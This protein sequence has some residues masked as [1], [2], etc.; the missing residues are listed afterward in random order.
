MTK[1]NIHGS[2]VTRD[3]FRFDNEQHFKVVNYI[4]RNSIISLSY[5]SVDLSS[6]NTVKDVRK[7][8]WEERMIYYDCNKSALKKIVSDDCDYLIID[9]IDE[10]FGIIESEKGN[11]TYSQV[12]QRSKQLNELS[13]YKVIDIKEDTDFFYNAYRDYAMFLREKFDVK[14]IIIHEVY[15][16][17]NYL[18]N[19]NKLHLFDENEIKKSKRVCSKIRKGYELLQ[20]FLPEA[21]VLKMPPNTIAYENHA[22]GKASVHFTDDYY[23]E[24]LTEIVGI[25]NTKVEEFSNA[26][27][28]SGI[29]PPYDSKYDSFKNVK[30]S[31]QL[32]T[33]NTVNAN[34]MENFNIDLQH[35][36]YQDI[37]GYHFEIFLY[38]KN[39]PKLYVVFG[40]ARTYKGVKR[41][42]P[43]FNRW[44]YCSFLDG[45]LL[46]IEDPMYY[47]YDDLLL[48]WFYGTDSDNGCR[49]G[50]TRLIQNIMNTLGIT[51]DNVCFYSSSGGGTVAI[52]MASKFEGSSAIT[53]NPQLE[54]SQWSYA[55]E[56]SKITGIDLQ[57]QDKWYRN[58]ISTQIKKAAKSRFVI[59]VNLESD[60][61]KAQLDSFAKKYNCLPAIGLNQYDNLI[62]WLYKAKAIMPHTAFETQELIWPIIYLGD[63][64]KQHKDINAYK[65]LYALIGDLWGNIWELNTKLT[66]ACKID[67][68][69]N[70]IMDEIEEQFFET[71][72]SNGFTFKRVDN[73]YQYVK[74]I[75][76]PKKGMIY[77]IHIEITE[78]FIP[79]E[80]ALYDFT[81]KKFI[82]RKMINEPDATLLFDNNYE[83]SND[84]SL[85]LYNGLI[86]NTEGNC[87]TVDKILTSIL[88][89]SVEL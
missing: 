22:W 61:D 56:F 84:C 62:I 45:N 78:N 76:K 73:S 54:I 32:I 37:N 39:S 3:I 87:M 4:G 83:N 50:L 9:L 59:C 7:L 82:N 15:P 49:E 75:D 19:D 41:D 29:Y 80:L 20:T 85:L 31:K 27:L 70:P 53:L 1:I 48:G 17:L 58:D 60:S 14:R 18:G 6:F 42:I 30:I 2:C 46:I 36:F 51:N 65:E 25:T 12:L 57:K 23:V 13:P 81:Q 10:R 74:I 67:S 52:Y 77:K 11:L 16:V 35:R 43:Y 72:Y 5:P 33:Q 8:T 79:Y 88:A 38:K 89:K 68:C 44:S 71:K 69:L 63:I 28:F 47:K 24:K 21:T 86:G 55:K 64:L 26:N 34:Y 66:N 40:G